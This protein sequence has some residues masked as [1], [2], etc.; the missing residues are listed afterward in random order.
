MTR[1][2]LFLLCVS[3]LLAAFG[4][5]A[6]LSKAM[7]LLKAEPLLQGESPL[8]FLFGTIVGLVLLVTV[9]ANWKRKGVAGFS[10]GAS[11]L[12]VLLLWILHIQQDSPLKGRAAWAFLAVLCVH[13][14]CW[15]TARGLRSDIC[16]GMNQKLSW[17]ELSYYLGVILGLGAEKLGL[18]DSRMGI[19]EALTLNVLLQAV[20]AII[21]QV[22][23]HG[24]KNEY[25]PQDY[26]KTHEFDWWR[27]A[28]LTA[29]IA[30]L[31]AGIEALFF[32]LVHRVQN[33]GNKVLSAE[34]WAVSYAGPALAALLGAITHVK[35]EWPP[36]G[37]LDAGAVQATNRWRH[38]R[39][40][41]SLIIWFSGAL[42]GL[43]ALAPCDRD[44]DRI[45]I[46]S[47]AV[48][49][50]FAYEIAYL[51]IG[52]RI[53]IEAKAAKRDGMVAVTL[54]VMGLAAAFATI[55][56]IHDLAPSRCGPGRMDA[57][58]RLRRRRQRPCPRPDGGWGSK[59]GPM[60]ETG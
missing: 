1:S 53:G 59:G 29:S 11:C 31:T 13:F 54:G 10:L 47:S 22:A 45:V 38:W 4:G 12:S 15:T 5:G 57:C 26:V 2:R 7:G 50:F 46:L 8:A 37:W 39:V 27:Y 28:K 51:A 42:M 18:D 60:T 48:A 30:L 17:I 34:I 52:D 14:G 20:A 43:I 35:L 16:S 6:I 44:W 56:V 19:T 33:D 25:K 23:L 58:I 24:L 32:G 3:N 9:P 36:G 40:P 55:A 49:V 41:L 21:D